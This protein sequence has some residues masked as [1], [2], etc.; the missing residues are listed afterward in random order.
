MRQISIYWIFRKKNQTQ[1]EQKKTRKLFSTKRK[2]KDDVFLWTMSTDCIPNVCFVCVRV[3]LSLMTRRGR[4]KKKRNFKWNCYYCSIFF[5]CPL[6]S[7][8]LATCWAKMFST[9]MIVSQKSIPNHDL[10][11]GGFPCQDYSV[12]RTGAQGIQG[13]KGVLWWQIRD[14]LAVVHKSSPLLL[15]FLHNFGSY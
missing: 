13:V 9:E 6:F 3:W 8:C 7:V 15:G 2:M 11:V 1:V 10:L 14:I 4:E 12:A 5:V